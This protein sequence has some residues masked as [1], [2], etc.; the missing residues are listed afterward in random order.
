MDERNAAPTGNGDEEKLA[1]GVATGNEKL[2]DEGQRDSGVTQEREDGTFIGGKDRLP[3]GGA[4]S[5]GGSKEG[6]VVETGMPADLVDEA[7]MKSQD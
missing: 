4:G 2:Q 5:A 1:E 6:H 7:S 3:T